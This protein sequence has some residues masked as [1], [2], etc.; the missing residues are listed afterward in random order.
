[1][2]F[3]QYFARTNVLLV[4]YIVFHSGNK[5]RVVMRMIIF[6]DQYILDFCAWLQ[7]WAPAE[8]VKISILHGFDAVASENGDGFAAYNPDTKTILCA[9]P[10]AMR[11][12]LALS[13]QD[14]VDTALTNIA[15]EYRHHIQFVNYTSPMLIDGQKLEEDAEDFAQ[16]ALTAYRTTH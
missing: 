11:E 4:Q 9:D 12:S 8:D 16:Q 10:C 14:A 6:A 3:C 5:Y 1:M 13:V 7:D 15:H 2:C